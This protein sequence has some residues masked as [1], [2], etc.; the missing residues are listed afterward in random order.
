MKMNSGLHGTDISVS[1]VTNIGPF[2]FWILVMGTEYFVPFD[3]YPVFKRASV[4]QIFNMESLSPSQ[5]YW[6][7]LDADIET[8]ALDNPEKYPLIW[9]D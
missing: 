4:Q 6:P 3:D 1:E 2:G 9:K 8:D 5:L 7:D